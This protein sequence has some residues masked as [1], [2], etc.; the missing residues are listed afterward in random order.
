[1]SLTCLPPPIREV[2]GQWPSAEHKLCEGNQAEKHRDRHH[3]LRLHGRTRDA[4]NR[5]RKG[6]VAKEKIDV[7]LETWL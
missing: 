3:E 6:R 7:H 4:V 5:I 1:M 2:R